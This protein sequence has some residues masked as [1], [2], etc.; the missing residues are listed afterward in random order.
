MPAMS[1]AVHVLAPWLDS[2]EIAHKSRTINGVHP[3][4]ISVAMYV[5]GAKMDRSSILRRL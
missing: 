5:Y 1:R 2:G 4:Q 3:M